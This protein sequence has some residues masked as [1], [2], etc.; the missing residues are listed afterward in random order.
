M[1]K[2]MAM[3]DKYYALLPQKNGLQEHFISVSFV[4]IIFSKTTI[5]KYILFKI[6]WQ[7]FSN[8]SEQLR[9]TAKYFYLELYKKQNN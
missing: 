5:W 7:S 3:L 2:Y 9:L 8:H 4:A 1:S 6:I